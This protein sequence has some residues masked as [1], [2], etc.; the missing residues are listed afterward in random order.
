VLADE[1]AIDATSNETEAV[2]RG[3]TPQTSGG[4]DRPS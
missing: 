4:R 2:N 1:A 3:E